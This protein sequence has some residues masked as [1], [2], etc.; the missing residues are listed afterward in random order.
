MRSIAVTPRRSAA[1]SLKL[2]PPDLAGDPER[3]ARML[4]EAR[5]AAS[6]NHPNICTIYEVGDAGGRH[7]I[8]MK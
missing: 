3:R 7:F 6:L 1:T 4:R 2:L 5:A 8:A